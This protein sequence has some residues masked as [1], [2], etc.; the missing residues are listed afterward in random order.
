MTNPTLFYTH[1]SGVKIPLSRILEISP[2]VLT[3]T[4]KVQYQI[5]ESVYNE[6][7]PL[8][9][10]YEAAIMA[11][12]QS[13]FEA[14][15]QAAKSKTFTKDFTEIFKSLYNQASSATQEFHSQ[16]GNIIQEAEDKV[17]Q[18][19][20]IAKESK[21]TI[22]EFKHSIS[23]ADLGKLKDELSA[24]VA[25]MKP[26]KVNLKEALDLINQ[27]FKDAKSS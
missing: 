2:S 13:D 20:Q 16:L 14:K 1:A 24:D 18:I 7:L 17:T 5:N 25:D 21:D 4:D 15:L 3:L 27:M 11:N 19:K 8:L 9:E 10:A 23:A 26:I 22:D 6:I 12:A